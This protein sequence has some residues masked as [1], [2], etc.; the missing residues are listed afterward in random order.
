MVELYRIIGSTP[1][2]RETGSGQ[3]VE[4]WTNK[5]DDDLAEEANL[6]LRGQGAIVEMIRRLRDSILAAEKATTRLTAVVASAKKVLIGVIIMVVGT[7]LLR[8]F[9]QV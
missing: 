4:D 9:G 6:G 7:L 5:S 2:S 3:M 1:D 8:L